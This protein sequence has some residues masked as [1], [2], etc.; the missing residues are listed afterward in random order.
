MCE[1]YLWLLSTYRQLAILK[2]DEKVVGRA[3]GEE[4]E[5]IQLVGLEAKF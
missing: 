1:N 2:K 3:S 4:Q 5:G